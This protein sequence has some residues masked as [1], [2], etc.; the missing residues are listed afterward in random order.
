MVLIDMPSPE[1]RLLA[2]EAGAL[3]DRMLNAIG[4]SRDTINLASL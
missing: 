4:R 2:G 1:A 3:F